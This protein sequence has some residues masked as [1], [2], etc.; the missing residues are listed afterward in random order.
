MNDL[1]LTEVC[2]QFGSGILRRSRAILRDATEAEDAT[3]EV[4]L[5][6]MQKGQQFRGDAELG[7]W[8]Y[9]LTTNLCLNRLRTRKRQSQREQSPEVASWLVVGVATPFERL[10]SRSDLEALL[11][12]FDE[13]GQQ[14]FVY[15]FL[16][17]LTQEEIAQTTGKSRRTVGKR[18]KELEAQLLEQL[19]SQA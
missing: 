14:I 17:G 12:S 11:A 15:A 6:V 8:I 9:K 1:D 5:A 4:L 7:A 10:S 2:R 19:G 13:L 16:D 18:L 3:Q